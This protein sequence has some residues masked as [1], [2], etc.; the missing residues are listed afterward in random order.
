MFGPEDVVG[1]LEKSSA[2]IP[3]VRPDEQS[4]HYV[5]GVLT[6]LTA[7]DALYMMAVYLLP[8]FPVVTAH[9]PFYPGGASLLVVV[10]VVMDPIAQMQSHLVSH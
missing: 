5:D 9:V 7:F 10:V 1:S 6:H 2:F 4:A 8:Q 3:D